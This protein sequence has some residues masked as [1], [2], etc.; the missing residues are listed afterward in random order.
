MFFL[1][2]CIETPVPQDVYKRLSDLEKRILH[3]EGLSPEY[4]RNN[5]ENMRDGKMSSGGESTFGSTQSLTLDEID[6][7]I[8][9]LRHSLSKGVSS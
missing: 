2:S 8:R 5:P 9:S 6:D 3:L 4:F 7:R 1:C